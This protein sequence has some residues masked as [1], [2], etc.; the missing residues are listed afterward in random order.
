MSASPRAQCIASHA[1][2]GTPS[3]FAIGFQSS[4]LSLRETL[5]GWFTGVRGRRV[6]VFPVIAFGEERRI[7]P[8][9]D[10]RKL[11]ALLLVPVSSLL[12]IV[13]VV[14]PAANGAATWYLQANVVPFHATAA[15]DDDLGI[16]S[17][18]PLS[19]ALIRGTR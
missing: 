12:E 1:R 7:I 8:I 9:V 14:Q 10:S 11:V 19:S 5:A 13:L 18:R 4:D 3:S 2:H 6:F 17:W 15:E 16:F